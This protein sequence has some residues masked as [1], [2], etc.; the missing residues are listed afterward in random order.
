MSDVQHLINY[1]FSSLNSCS[2][3]KSVLESKVKETVFETYKQAVIISQPL[4][5]DQQ[6]FIS[7]KDQQEIPFQKLLNKKLS[8]LKCSNC[9]LSNFQNLFICLQC[10]H[11]GC[12]DNFNSHSQ[13]HYKQTQHM[14]AIDAKTG[15][16]YCF[17]CNL[18]VNHD[19]LEKI[20][21]DIMHN[22]YYELDETINQHY[23]NPNKFA[24]K[25]LKGFVNLGATCFMSSILQTFIHNPILKHKFFNNDEHFFNC[26][27]NLNNDE[28]DE[29]NSCITCSIDSIFQIFFTSSN[30]EGYGITNLLI[31]SWYKKKS[32][33][34]FQEQDAHEFWQFLLNEFHQD[35]TRIKA[36]QNQHSIDSEN[37][38]CIAHST[39]AFKLQSC[40]K[41]TNCNKITE[42]IDPIMDLS[43]EINHLSKEQNTLYDCLNLYTKEEKLDDN[44]TCKFCN[45]KAEQ[46]VKQLKIKTIPK[47]LSI[48]LKRFEH[49]VMNDTSSKIE[50]PIKIPLYLD[51]S[52]YTTATT[53]DPC[54]YELFS[55]VVHQGS[56]NTG[57]YI[58]YVKSDNR[59]FKFDDAVISLS[60]ED[61][62]MNANVYLM[63]FIKKDI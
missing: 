17:K 51:L 59:W 9:E 10:P 52:K 19:H 48:Q 58:C 14:F 44:Y 49:N 3:L 63:F 62:V 54:L 60:S 22:E 34:G 15:L 47:I 24:I 18:F 37:C 39:F 8:S 53:S 38:S 2:H 26:N 7:K 21:S 45:I 12:H 61:E 11:I 25:G 43:L 50:T 4:L 46:A 35:F 29:N 27:V 23:S 28:I 5:E 20:R 33:A 55:V 32:L 57:H 31:T 16:L 1:N 13:L 41:C 42:T 40:I 56:V 30:Q 36:N 6:T